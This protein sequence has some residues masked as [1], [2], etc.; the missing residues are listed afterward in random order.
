MPLALTRQ[1]TK[2]KLK[3]HTAVPQLFV[4]NI[5]VHPG[6]QAVIWILCL[7]RMWDV[8][9]SGTN[10]TTDKNKVKDSYRRTPIICAQYFGAPWSTS[11]DL[12]FMFRTDLGRQCLWQ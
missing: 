5:L 6:V 10:K 2:I 4:P 7:E 12:D 1:Q 11:G 3:I 9:A 8:N